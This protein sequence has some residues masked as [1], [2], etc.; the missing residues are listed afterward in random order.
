MC[1]SY[2]R[3]KA[4]L[5]PSP[6]RAGA[7]EGDADP[8]RISDSEENERSLITRASR[9]SFQEAAKFSLRHLSSAREGVRSPRP[10]PCHAAG[11]HTT[12]P[13]P[14]ARQPGEAQDEPGRR[15]PGQLGKPRP[16]RR[17]PLSPLPHSGA[18]A[19]RQH[20]LS[21]RRAAERRP[22]AAGAKVGPAPSPRP[23]SQR[24]PPPRS[25]PSPP[26]RQGRPAPAVPPGPAPVAMAVRHARRRPGAARPLRGAA[27]ISRPRRPEGSCPGETRLLGR[28]LGYK[29][30]PAGVGESGGPGRGGLPHPALAAPPAEVSENSV[31]STDKKGLNHASLAR[32]FRFSG[33]STFGAS[34]TSRVEALH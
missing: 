11:P 26:A 19:R 8:L 32:E 33:S 34:V 3:P 10:P 28:S 22:D 27:A 20:R 25:P 18:C 23:C 30:S 5:P 14:T 29:A 1:G 13:V 9:R 7:A 15:E 17:P 2:K 16:S 21:P 24:R 31:L 6:G 12:P 4:W